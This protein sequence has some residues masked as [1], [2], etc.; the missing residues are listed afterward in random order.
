[1]AGT[2]EDEHVEQRALGLISTF[3][4]N[5]G[6]DLPERLGHGYRSL[7]PMKRD[8]LC[9]HLSACGRTN[10]RADRAGCD[11]LMQIRVRMAFGRQYH[12]RAAL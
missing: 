7:C 6:G 4:N 2:G 10:K 9:V 1:M 8:I 3:F 11:H 12:R 5:L